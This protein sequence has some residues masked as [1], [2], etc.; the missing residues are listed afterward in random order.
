[1]DT[2]TGRCVHQKQALANIPVLICY[3]VNDDVTLQVDASSKTF[4]ESQQN[5][6]QIEKEA[7]AVASF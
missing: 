1:M 6:P 3:D 5:Y 4:T 7:S 2:G